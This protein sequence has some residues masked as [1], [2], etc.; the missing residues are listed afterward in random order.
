MKPFIVTAEEVAAFR[1]FIADHERATAEEIAISCD[2][3]RRMEHANY[4]LGQMYE[5]LIPEELK[6]PQ[7]PDWLKV[8]Q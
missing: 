7:F 1:Q 6:N 5:F 8:P 2:L 3:I 4:S